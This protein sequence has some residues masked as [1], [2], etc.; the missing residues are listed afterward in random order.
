MRCFF[1][2]SGSV[3]DPDDEGAEIASLAEARLEAVRDLS[4]CLRDEPHLVWQGEELRMDVTDH[5]RMIL[6]TVIVLGIDAPAAM[7]LR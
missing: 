7:P 1:N 5:N 6:C 2:L 4:I 3:I